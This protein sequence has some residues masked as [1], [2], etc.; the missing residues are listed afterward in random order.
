[1]C[2]SEENEEPEYRKQLRFWSQQQKIGDQ[3]YMKTNVI[4]PRK[5]ASATVVFDPVSSC[6][7][8]SLPQKATQ[9]IFG[10]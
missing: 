7:T 9:E 8:Q 10:Q 4:Y 3:S 6:L 2:H 5:V 1:M